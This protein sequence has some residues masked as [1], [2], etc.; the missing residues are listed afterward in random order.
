MFFFGCQYKQILQIN[1]CTLTNLL[2]IPQI[3]LCNYFK[4]CYNKNTKI[5]EERD[6]KT[7]K[8]L[9]TTLL[10]VFVIIT[11]CSAMIS[12]F[13]EHAAMQRTAAR[14]HKF[15]FIFL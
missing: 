10:S 4:L 7:T 12:S 14:S 1:L 5:K 9:L 2:K 6:L 3:N 13:C 11:S 15:F 8:R